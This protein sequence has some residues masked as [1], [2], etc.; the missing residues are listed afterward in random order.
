MVR[1]QMWYEAVPLLFT[2]QNIVNIAIFTDLTL[3][4]PTK[5]FRLISAEWI[6]FCEMTNIIVYFLRYFSGIMAVTEL[7]REFLG[8]IYHADF[9]RKWSDL[10]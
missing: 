10:A 1:D 7:L 5:F 6:G 8:K 2:P 3:Y 9:H 4:I